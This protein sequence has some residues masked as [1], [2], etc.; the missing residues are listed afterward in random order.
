[1]Y[2]QKQ[3]KMIKVT[4]KDFD[5]VVNVLENSEHRIT[6]MYVPKWNSIEIIDGMNAP[7]EIADDVIEMLDKAGLKVGQGISISGDSSSYSRG[8]YESIERINGGHKNYY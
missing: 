1:M 6:V 2:T 5:R 4:K 3:L 7:D 8:E